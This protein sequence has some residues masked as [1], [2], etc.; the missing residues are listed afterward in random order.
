MALPDISR[1]KNNIPA[2][3][4][5][6]VMLVP[7]GMAYAMLAGL[8]PVTGLYAS[9]IPLLAYAIFGTSRELAIGPVAMVSLLVY[10]ECSKLAEPGSQEYISLALSLAFM[11]G[12]IQIIFAIARMGFIINFFS[13][14]VIS[15]FT[16]AAAI[17][18]MVSQL[19]HVTGISSRG[20]HAVL[21]RLWD[22]MKSFKDWHLTTILLSAGSVAILMFFKKKYKKF[23]SQLLVAAS[24]ILIVWLLNLDALGVQIVGKIPSGLPDFTLPGLSLTNLI[25]LFPS[26][27]V[28]VFIGFM[29]SIA[30]ARYIAEKEKYKISPDGELLGLGAANLVASFF[31]GYPVTGGFSRTAV[32]YRAGA[33]S[34]LAG[35]ITSLAVLAAVLFLAGLFRHLPNAVLATI[36]IVAVTTLMDFREPVR[37]YRLKKT[38]GLAWIVTF[39]LTLFW[40]VQQGL[41][42]GVIFSLAVFIRRSSHPYT[43]VL[44]YLEEEKIF[45]N[46]ERFPEARTFPGA[47][48]LR[49]DASLYF[50]NMG[51]VEDVIRSEILEKG[52]VRF[53][54]LDLSGVNA[55]D[56]EALSRL[57]KLM[58]RL[59]EENISFYYAGMKG[60]VRDIVS[61]SRF[62]EHF[63]KN[64][65]PSVRLALKNAGFTL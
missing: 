62:Q 2:G 42:A 43:A 5:V 35:V 13:H 44:G 59:E 19:H 20:D 47:L 39:L 36:I 18:I 55:M 63:K 58:S 52:D 7:Q 8:P 49:V 41:V 3:L 61:R 51:F 57:E 50:A 22:V 6:A 45:R 16:S 27:L 46:V 23:P 56:A 37:L 10:A 40:G 30:I 33:T 25:R 11:C 38:D 29:E 24:S 32:N 4:T 48:I 26:A 54:I 1:F 15:G 65:Y 64:S 17:I 21:Y 31:S 12:I 28:I 14:S 9:T 60:A 34:R 53:I